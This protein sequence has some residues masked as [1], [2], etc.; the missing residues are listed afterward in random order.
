MMPVE[1][2][3]MRFPRMVRDLARDLGKRVRPD[4]RGRATPSSTAP[5]IEQPSHPLMHMLR[6][7]VDHGLESPAEREAAGKPPRARSGSRV[8]TRGNSVVIEI[9]DDGKGI[10]PERLRASAVTKGLLAHE[11]AD[12]LT[13][14]EAL[15]L[16]FLPGLLDAKTHRRL[17]P[18][19]GHG[20]GAHRDH[21]PE[22]RG[23]DPQRAGAAAAS[24]P[25]A[26]R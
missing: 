4:H 13:E 7:C 26:C 11:A 21:R 14:R 23:H 24:S 20:R 2:V 18:R 3:F 22:R 25:S 19:R 9:E 1:A 10:D 6:N 12:A 16:I 5:C 15:D 8:A 17:G